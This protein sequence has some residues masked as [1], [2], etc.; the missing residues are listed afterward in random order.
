MKIFNLH[1]YSEYSF[2]RSTITIEKLVKKA[3]N[4]GISHLVLTDRNSLA[5]MPKFFVECKKNNVQPIIGIDLEIEN[6]RLILIAKNL[7]GYLKLVDLSSKIKTK[8]KIYIEEIEESENY[9]II[10]HPTKGILD[11]ENKIFSFQNFFYNSLNDNDPKAIYIKEN[12]LFENSENEILEALYFT[13]TGTKKKFNFSPLEFHIDD[14][15]ISKKIIFNTNNLIKNINFELPNFPVDLPKIFPENEKAFFDILKKKFTEKKHLFSDISLA[16]KR[17][18]YESKIIKNLNFIDYFLVIHDFVAFA[19]SKNIMIGPGRGS[20]AGSLIAFLLEITAIN[21][22]DFD[23]IFERFLNPKRVSMPDIDLDFQDDRRKEIIDYLITK[24]GKERVALIATF[25]T[26]GAKSSIRDI[27]RFL[28]IEINKIDQICKLLGKF[29]T[30]EEAYK[31][32]K[33]FADTIVSSPINQKLYEM[34]CKIQGLPRQQGIHA[35]GIV[36]NSEKITNRVPVS[37][38]DG[39]FITTQFS[40]EYLENFGLIKIDILGL[41]NLTIIKNILNYVN[42]NIDPNFQLTT[43]KFSNKNAFQLLAQGKTVGIFQL[44]SFGMK[45]VLEKL[46]VDCFEDIYTCISLYRP[47]PMDNIDSFIKRKRKLEEIPK[48]FPGYDK[49]LKETYG[50][51]IFQ[52]QIIK[53]AQEI[54]GFSLA[55]ADIFRKAIGKKDNQLM[56]KLKQKFILGALKKGLSKEKAYFIYNEIE[57]FANYGFN[58]SHAVSYATISYWMAI[59]KSS[60]YVDFLMWNINANSSDHKIVK[61]YADEAFLANFTI[62]GPEINFS[63]KNCQF[64]NN[65]VYLPFFLIKGLGTSAIQKLEEEK[66]KGHF[67]SLRDCICRLKNC[68]FGEANF[69]ILTLSNTLRNFANQNTILENY[70]YLKKSCIVKNLSSEENQTTIKEQD[71]KTEIKNEILY[72][73]NQYNFWEKNFNSNLENSDNLSNLKAGI[74]SRVVVGIKKIILKKYKDITK[75]EF[76]TLKVFDSKKEVDCFVNNKILTQ[77]KNTI[78]VDKN[79]EIEITLNKNGNYFVSKIFR[80]IHN[81]K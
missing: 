51:I 56:Q 22:L 10:N 57:K 12:C 18:L 61:K 75:G 21:P 8:N 31:N 79:Y 74:S 35:A 14:N 32:S 4:E 80:E 60:F 36:L 68:N 1:T 46:Q 2:L 48:V 55:E 15:L 20:S 5:G 39:E 63:S 29:K 41:K 67:K 49:I 34:A 13:K 65:K 73:G 54:S 11:I 42:K 43:E 66:Q 16:K 64:I 6:F 40:M 9:L 38:I 58:K 47:G 3:S 44:E 52:E 23:L 30:L 28:N 7:Q 25:Q 53:I 26:L 33:V 72:L 45:K 70:E 76:M 77:I 27:G 62:Q 59:L 81:E 17:L 78:Q 19:K 37:T 50:I 24:Y 71:K 69:K